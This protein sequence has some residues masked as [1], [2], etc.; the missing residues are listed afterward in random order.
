MRHPFACLVIFLATGSLV[1]VAPQRAEACDPAPNFSAELAEE[2]AP[3][4]LAFSARGDYG[5][6]S[7]SVRN[8][9]IGDVTLSKG[10]DC[11]AC[12]DTVTIATAMSP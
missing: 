12:A 6:S 1:L 5:S 11:A 4:C 8:D 2:D 3:E 7:L 10:D 9:C